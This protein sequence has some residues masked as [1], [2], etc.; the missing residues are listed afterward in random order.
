[1]SGYA[2]A[3]NQKNSSDNAMSQICKALR[4]HFSII[5]SAPPHSIGPYSSNFS[6][7]HNEWSL[8]RANASF[9]APNLLYLEK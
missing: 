1:M 8:C 5:P 7:I 6:E 3:S 4:L 9:Q 2:D